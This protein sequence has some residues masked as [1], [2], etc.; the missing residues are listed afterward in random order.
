MRWGAADP[1][2]P[3]QSAHTVS[4]FTG[5]SAPACSGRQ[6]SGGRRSR[7]LRNSRRFA[8]W[9]CRSA[10]SAPPRTTRSSSPLELCMSASGGGT[11]RPNAG[12]TTSTPVRHSRI[13]TAPT[14]PR[15]LPG[16]PIFGGASRNLQAF[17][18]VPDRRARAPL[19]A[20]VTINSLDQARVLYRTCFDPWE[21]APPRPAKETGATGANVR[22]NLTKT[23]AL[24]DEALRLQAAGF[25][26]PVPEHVNSNVY[27]RAYEEMAIRSKGATHRLRTNDVEENEMHKGL[28][29]TVNGIEDILWGRLANSCGPYTTYKDAIIRDFNL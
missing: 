13:D 5:P 6:W 17:A 9:P 2:R 4:T 26:I 3:A 16:K 22:L 20:A 8:T 11:Q 14:D 23:T 19:Y 10:V 28:C 25:P 29:W 27:D 7:S 21:L 1:T 12:S 24:I 15:R 18:P